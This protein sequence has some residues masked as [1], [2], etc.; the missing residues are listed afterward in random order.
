[1]IVHDRLGWPLLDLPPAV[2]SCSSSCNIYCLTHAVALCMTGAPA[3]AMCALMIEHI[4]PWPPALSPALHLG[5]IQLITSNGVLL[6]PGTLQLYQPSTLN[7]NVTDAGAC[8]DGDPST[9]CANNNATDEYPNLTISYPCNTR[10][11]K[12]MVMN[13]NDCCQ[14]AITGFAM[15]FRDHT[16][17]LLYEYQFPGAQQQYSI[18]R[19]GCESAGAQLVCT[20]WL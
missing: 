6:T 20:S 5:E 1:M 12:V 15:R 13:R 18:T 4:D 9:M 2:N 14:E 11:V 17:T 3:G 16:N 7:P 10:V 19:G 8:F